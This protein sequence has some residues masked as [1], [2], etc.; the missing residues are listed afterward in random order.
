MD[1]V[2]SLLRERRFDDARGALDQVTYDAAPGRATALRGRLAALQGDCV[3]AK[4][5]FDQAERKAPACAPRTASSASRL[6]N[7]C[8]SARRVVPIPRWARLATWA[9][10]QRY[11]PAAK[12][13]SWPLRT[14]S[15]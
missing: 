9:Q 11:F 7:N 10:L 1:Q 14:I 15:S 4:Q 6:K 2:E 13:F 8:D 3:K 5:L 12:W